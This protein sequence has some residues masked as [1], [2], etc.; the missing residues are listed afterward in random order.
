MTFLCSSIWMGGRKEGI[1]RHT[2]TTCMGRD[3]SGWL[4]K[5]PVAVGDAW[6][7]LD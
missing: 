3:C 2:D 7:R 1:R 5:G 6:V 4:D